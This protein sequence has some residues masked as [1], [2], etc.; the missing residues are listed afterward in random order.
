MW[1]FDGGCVLFGAM[2]V[3][4]IAVTLPQASGGVIGF[5]IGGGIGLRAAPPSPSSA[6]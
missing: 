5:A 1:A 4:E 3:A 6:L 2:S